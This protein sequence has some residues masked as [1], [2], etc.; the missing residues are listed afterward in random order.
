MS[1]TAEG[2]FAKLFTM[3]LLALAVTWF[4][5]LATISKG[6]T[7]A[8]A[9]PSTPAITGP[10]ILGTALATAHT[11]QDL[12][13]IKYDKFEGR[14]IPDAGLYYE[15]VSSKITCLSYCATDSE[16][17]SFFYIKATQSCILHTIVYISQNDTVKSD[18]AS[19]YIVGDKNKCPIDEGF[20]HKRSLN[21]CYYVVTDRANLTA[22]VRTC[23][24]KDAQFGYPFSSDLYDHFNDVLTGSFLFRK[25]EFW[26][27]IV[28]ED[29][30]TD[31]KFYSDNS[32][33]N[34]SRWKKSEPAGHLCVVTSLED[35][36]QWEST[37]CDRSKAY[38]CSV[39][40]W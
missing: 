33:P 10:W 39:G 36:W 29:G 17:M 25:R 4:A 40:I 7:T 16:C 32:I 24:E 6:M 38:V 37:G 15:N 21:A 2:I 28:L 8:T 34:F 35:N 18:S 22:A 27:G 20:F 26:T 19:Y 5:T 23:R 13:A 31:Y 30:H 14:V 1:L 11:K 9:I 3:T 12:F